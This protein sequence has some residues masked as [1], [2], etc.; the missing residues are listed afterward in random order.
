MTVGAKAGRMEVQMVAPTDILRVFV[1]EQ[2]RAAVMVVDLVFLRVACTD[3]VVMTREL[4][5]FKSKS[6]SKGARRLPGRLVRRLG[7]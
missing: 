6:C 2:Q 3:C 7:R 1:T 4:F 5:G